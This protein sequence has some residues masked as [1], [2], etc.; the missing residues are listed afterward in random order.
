MFKDKKVIVV[1]PAYNAEKTLRMTYEEVMAQAVVDLRADL[2]VAKVSTNGKHHLR[3][4][5]E[6]I[7]RQFKTVVSRLLL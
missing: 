1:M 5:V 7:S 4:G 3:M 2:S 6:E